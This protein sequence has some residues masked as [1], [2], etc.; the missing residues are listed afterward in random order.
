MPLIELDLNRID[1]QLVKIINL[2]QII[3]WWHDPT[4][5]TATSRLCTHLPLKTHRD[6]CHSTSRPL[7]LTR[8]TW[9][10]QILAIWSTAQQTLSINLTTTTTPMACSTVLRCQW[11]AQVAMNIC[12]R[13]T[14]RKT[15]MALIWAT[16]TDLPLAMA[17][18]SLARE[19]HPI[20]T[21]MRT[22]LTCMIVIK[23]LE[24]SHPQASTILKPTWA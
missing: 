4:T 8:V 21:C 23:P 5:P 10:Q 16:G 19:W 15:P 24:A 2:S 6:L 1:E 13:Q 3:K 11:W 12:M 17:S 18:L 22:P 20:S 7:C 9:F 14:T